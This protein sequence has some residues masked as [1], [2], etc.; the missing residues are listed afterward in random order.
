MTR[1]EDYFK[2]RL[3][4][5]RRRER[6]W[7][8]LVKYLARV[9]PHE[10]DVLE[11]GAGYCYFINNIPA[12]RRVAVDLFSGL[13]RHAASGVDARVADALSFLREC[14]PASFDFIFASNFFEHFE[15]PALD[16]LLPL[17]VRALRPGGRLGIV[18][19]NFRT[20]SRRYFDDFT[21][22][23]IFTDVSLRDWLTAHG[24]VVTHLDARFLPLTVKGTGGSL[25]FLVPLYLRL[26]IRPLA[27]QM[28][29]IAERRE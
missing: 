29:A 13:P 28:L 18:Q 10:A 17:I 1:A 3:V 20:A 2:T 14:P 24:L 16:Q 25:T 6:L 8:H 19:P 12:K 9:V 23:T 22:R 21:H 4:E 15:W 7:Q 26:P 27:G 11:L 5:D